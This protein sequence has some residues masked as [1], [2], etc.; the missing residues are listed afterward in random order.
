MPV[1][2]VEVERMLGLVGFVHKPKVV[3]GVTPLRGSICRLQLSIGEEVDL[4]V[5]KLLQQ[6]VI[7]EAVSPLV[8]TRKRNTNKVRFCVVFREPSKV[9]VTDPFHYRIWKRC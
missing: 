2:A 6:D 1:A 5:Q 7:E 4:E 9:I 8:F 3:P